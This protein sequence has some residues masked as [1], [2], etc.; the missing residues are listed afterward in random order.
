MFA[1]P[2]QTAST[3]SG[4]LRGLHYSTTD[5]GQYADTTPERVPRRT[6][7]VAD[8]ALQTA[9]ALLSVSFEGRSARRPLRVVVRLS[10]NLYTVED[11][12]LGVSG[13]GLTVEEAVTDFVAFLMFD[14]HAYV[15]EPEQNLDTHAQAL[16]VKYQELFG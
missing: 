13:A 8:S 5:G 14:Y 1:L 7:Y 4:G 12:G 15:D 11:E 6:E 16:R 10:D 2:V 3:A 9:S